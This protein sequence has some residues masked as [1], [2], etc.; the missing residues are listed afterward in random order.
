MTLK[1]AT[2]FN[3]AKC[4]YFFNDKI[5]EKKLIYYDA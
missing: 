1:D 5:I 4:Q 2:L 3:Y